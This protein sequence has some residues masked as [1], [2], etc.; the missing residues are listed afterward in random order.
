MRR[1]RESHDHIPQR[2]EDYA[3]IGDCRTAALVSREG[4]IDW[5][6]LPRFDS[7]ACFAALLGRGENGHWRIAPRAKSQIQ[8]RYRQ[9]GLVLETRFETRAGVVLLVDFMPIGHAESSVVRLVLGCAGCVALQSELVIRF[10]YGVTV[11]WV[12]R[13]PDGALTAVAGPH[14]LVLRTPAPLKGQDLR[15]IARF[16][17]AAG[18]TIPFV[19]S[20]GASHLPLPKALNVKTAL[21]RTERFW[22]GWTRRCRSAGEWS[23][24]LRRSL[25][26]LKGLSY[27]PTGGIVAAPTTSLPERLGG[28][29][30]WDYRYCWLRDATFTLV[31]L[32]DAGYRD[33]AQAWRDWLLRAVA[34]SPEQLQIM[35]GLGGERRL[36]EW[37]LPWLPGHAGSAPVRVGNAAASQLQLDVYGEIANALALARRDGLGALPRSGELRQTWLHHLEKIWRLP[38]SGIW[39]IRGKP[40]HF[41]HSKVMAWVAFNCA[42]QTRH[43]GRAERFRNHWRRIASRIHR[44][45][46]KNALDPSGRYFVQSY[47]SRNLDASLLLLP[48]VGFLPAQDSRIRATVEAIERR[49]MV[50]G[51]V[52][53]Y[54]SGRGVDALPPG[55]GAFLACSFWL[56]D[57]Y[58]LLGRLTEARALFRRLA[59]LCNDVGLLSEEYDPRARRFL[60]NFPQ[61]FSHVAL[62]NTALGLMREKPPRRAKRGAARGRLAHGPHREA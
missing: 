21:A 6:C 25:I 32:M 62:V 54:D 16:S 12:T 27:A 42:V 56:A 46:C 41:T 45:I 18:E 26:T 57:N 49:L 60:G 23:E 22:R 47:G 19:L 13:L 40:R 17:V 35:Y 59:A 11:P 58:V 29:R 15:T 5:L 44:D 9:G 39:E 31:A 7:G 10:D 8:R 24:P 3:M 37:E 48:I 43:L 4:S 2:I 51:L 33:E 28:V 61:A 50:D 38:D 30:N 20:H 52:M 34:G 14:K 1:V 55:E 53:R 36:D